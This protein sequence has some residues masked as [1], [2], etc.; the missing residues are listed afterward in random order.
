MSD[1]VSAAIAFAQAHPAAV[2]IGVG[3]LGAILVVFKHGVLGKLFGILLIVA[4]IAFFT[5]VSALGIPAHF[6]MEV[7]T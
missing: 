5:G 7:P 1:P 2:A 4:A 6:G 3:L